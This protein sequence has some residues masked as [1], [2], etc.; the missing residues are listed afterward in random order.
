[1]AE[2]LPDLSSLPSYWLGRMVPSLS[3]GEF[4]DDP[5]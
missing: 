5:N 2:L 4:L 1:M 3:W